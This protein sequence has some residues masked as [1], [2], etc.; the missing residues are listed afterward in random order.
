MNTSSAI[1]YGAVSGSVTITA[2][3]CGDD[4]VLPLITLGSV[5]VSG[6]ALEA[7]A[8]ACLAELDLLAADDD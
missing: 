2:H 6:A 1:C 8:R 3:G 5:P 7:H 4:T